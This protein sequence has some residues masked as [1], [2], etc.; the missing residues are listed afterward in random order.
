MGSRGPKR[1][2]ARFY[3]RTP[4]GVPPSPRREF[5]LEH[6][7]RL[8][9]VE[10]KSAP[11]SRTLG[12]PVPLPRTKGKVKGAHVKRIAT[13]A[14]AA[15]CLVFL[16]PSAGVSQV[17]YQFPD[18]AIV[19]A[20]E[21]ALG[22]Y[23]GA[24]DNELFRLG[25]FARMNATK[26]LDVGLEMLFDSAAG[27]GRFGAGGDLKFD[28]IP[29]TDA[30]PFDLSMTSGIGVIKSDKIRIVQFPVGGV[31]SSPFQLDSGNIIAL[32]LGVYMLIIDTKLERTDLPAYSDTELDVEARGGI[33][34]SLSSGP[35]I[36]VGFQAGHEAMVTVGAS[37]WPK[38]QQD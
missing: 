15:M 16:A 35:D 32:Y 9:Y 24:G 18:A 20:G 4:G 2:N 38:R 34:Y 25:G 11:R 19:R 6:G 21:F 29:D 3:T 12:A 33:R 37:F 26:Y 17:F 27:D 28:L 13:A 31:I 8:L 5:C 30:I 1:P 7:A 10:M 23:G 14:A 22:P 36:F